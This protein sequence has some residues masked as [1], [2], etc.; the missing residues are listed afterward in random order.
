[1]VSG[2][3]WLFL[4]GQSEGLVNRLDCSKGLA[5]P[6]DIKVVYQHLRDDLL[7]VLITVE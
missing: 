7:L 1:V 2:V 3:V 5:K 6:I 4:G